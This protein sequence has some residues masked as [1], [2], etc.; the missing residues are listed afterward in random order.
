MKRDFDFE[1]VGKQVPYQIPEGFFEE[2]QKNVLEQTKKRKTNNKTLVLRLVPVIS[3]AAAVVAAVLFLP[4]HTEQIKDNSLTQA[5]VVD[6]A[7]IEHVSDEDLQMMSDFSDYD[8][9]MNQE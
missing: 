1:E 4:I 2:M 5:T 3:A 8:I 9:F 6:D 7:W